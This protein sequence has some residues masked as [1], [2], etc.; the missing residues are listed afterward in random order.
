MAN[1]IIDDGLAV[2]RE[3]YGHEDGPRKV[4]EYLLQRILEEEAAEHLGA[5]RHQRSQGRRGHRNGYKPRKLQG[6]LGTMDLQVPQVRNCEPYQPS[7]WNKWQRHERALL[8][9]C[10]EMYFQGVSTRKVQKVLKVMCN[11][12]LSAMTVSRV[13]A[14]LDEKLEQFRGRSLKA[15]AYPYLQIDAR[16]EHVR[17]EGQVVS[18]AVLV[19]IGFN[20]LGRKEILDWRVADSESQASW[21]ELF[22]DLK[23]RGLHGVLLITSDAHKGIRA[24]I[25]KHFQGVAWQR[26]QVHFKRELSKRVASR[27]YH[28]LQQDLR[29]VFKASTLQEALVLREEM[30][31]KWKKRYP[32]VAQRLQEVEDCLAVLAFPQE[33]QRRLASTNHAESLMRQLR[34][35]TA[36]VNIFPSVGS[37][38]R[39][40]GALLIQEH[41]KWAKARRPVFN[42]ADLRPGGSG[43]TG[44]QALAAPGPREPGQELAG[45]RE[46][47]AAA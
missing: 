12:E 33:H 11:Y 7:L 4:V 34:R 32:G 27:Y 41:E 13:A 29:L 9:T 38:Q 14:E 45:R 30:A 1:E 15:L 19:V 17:I 24:A 39:L 26:C 36:V 23:E 28:E 43:E 31:S 18:Q 6:R 35:R 37:C 42:L 20:A 10:A 8:C 22:R 47:V 44:P 46:E 2:M 3:L 25:E 5:G 21:V 16:Y 40:I